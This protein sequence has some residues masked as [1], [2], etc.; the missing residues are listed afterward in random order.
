[1][2]RIMN[3]RHSLYETITNDMLAELKRGVAPWV[4]PW[5]E[6]GGSVPLLPYNALT[7]K[8]YHGV[9]VLI[10]WHAA[11]A[12]GYRHPGWIGYH[13]ALGLGGHVKKDEKSTV[14]VYGSTFVPKGERG[15]PEEEQKR[16]PFLKKRI[17]FNVEQTENLPERLTR[18]PEPTPLPEALDHVEAF[19]RRIGA[20]VLHGGDRAAYSPNF[21]LITLPEPARFESISHYYATSLHEHGHWTGHKSRLDRDLAGRFGTESYAA[22]ELVAEL[23]AAYLCA[24]LAIPGRLRH[25]EYLGHWIALLSHDAR[26][27]FTAA[28]K[29][30]DA[31]RFL[32][33][34]GGLSPD[35]ARTEE[36]GAGEREG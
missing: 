17:V 5:S 19:L 3:A 16:V 20:K 36:N 2:R 34:A 18:L 6:G 1:M 33:T 7:R 9:N 35:E 27:L 15:K 12:K 8:R 13:Q 14:I 11:L 31:A 26:A 29:A 28:S 32:E 30:T 10:L 21:D 22:E 4:K 25:A 24:L 23:A